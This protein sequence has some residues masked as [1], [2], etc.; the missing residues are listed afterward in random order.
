VENPCGPA[1]A[2]QALRIAE[3]C[4]VSRR[5]GRAVAVEEIEA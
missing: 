4:D 2:L 5:E 3:A 1:D